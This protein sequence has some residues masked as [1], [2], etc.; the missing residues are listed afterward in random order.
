V[1][2]IIRG[3]YYAETC[4]VL[5]TVVLSVSVIDLLSAQIRA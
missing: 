3:V 5:I 2:E 1:W 4:A